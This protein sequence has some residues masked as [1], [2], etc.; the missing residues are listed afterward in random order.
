MEPETERKVVWGNFGARTL[1]EDAP[2][3][4]TWCTSSPLG[5]GNLFPFCLRPNRSLSDFERTCIKSF[6]AYTFPAN[7]WQLLSSLS[8]P[9]RLGF[10][11]VSQLIAFMEW[12]EP[13]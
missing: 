11:T 1:P 9:D 4:I 3:K 12:V 6:C 10:R 2:L 5:E 13:T 8:E 7:Q